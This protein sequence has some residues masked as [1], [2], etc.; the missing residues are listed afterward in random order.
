[1]KELLEALG[2]KL[3]AKTVALELSLTADEIKFVENG[4]TKNKDTDSRAELVL[5]LMALL[6]SSETQMLELKSHLELACKLFPA[7]VNLRDTLTKLEADWAEFHKRMTANINQ[8][9]CAYK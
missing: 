7:K 6:Q 4:L 3:D 5:A 8:V 9:L 1:M 2:I